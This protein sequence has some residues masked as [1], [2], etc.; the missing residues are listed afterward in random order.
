MP[1]VHIYFTTLTIPFELAIYLLSIVVVG[2]E[3]SI[4]QKDIVLRLPA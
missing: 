4:I 1:F 2:C 3:M